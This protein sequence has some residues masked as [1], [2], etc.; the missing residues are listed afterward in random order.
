[1]IDATHP[2]AA[3]ISAHV[4]LACAETGV[5][6]LTLERPPWQPRPGDRWIE[7]ADTTEAA[8]ALHGFARVWLTIGSSDLAAFTGMDQTWFLI[9]MIGPPATP[10][11]L[12]HYELILGKGPF[13]LE[14]EQHLIKTHRIEALVTKASGGPP[15]A[16]LLAAREAEMPVVMIRRPE[17][18]LG[19]SVESVAT[20]VDR[21]AK[22]LGAEGKGS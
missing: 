9:R 22:Y 18:P 19:E 2:F 10:L 5:P 20:A 11:P 17:K 12:R 8:K 1:V 4:A 3:Q 16:K 15:P 13:S 7:V 14:A 21:V 6:L